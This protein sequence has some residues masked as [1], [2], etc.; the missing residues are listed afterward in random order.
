MFREGQEILGK[1]YEVI[2]RFGGDAFGEIYLVKKSTTGEIFVAKVEKSAIFQKHIML[3]W[4]AKILRK[5]RDKTRV[6]NL[7]FVG[8]EKID[9]NHIY[10][11]IVMDFLGKSLENLF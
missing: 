2:K 3:Y 7:H 1:R 4:E 10:R 6:P 9:E 8:D 11:V 5:L